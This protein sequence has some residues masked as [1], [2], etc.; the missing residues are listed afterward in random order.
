MNDANRTQMLDPNRTQLGNAPTLD[1]NRTVMGNAPSLNATQT[2]KPVQCPVCKSFNPTG[3]MFCVDCGLIFERAL[4]DDAFGAPAIQV[5]QLVDESGREQPLRPGETIIGRE[6][7]IMVTDGRASRRHAKITSANDVLHLE[8]L[9]STNGTKLNGDKLVAGEKRAIKGGDKI[10]FGGLEM[11][12]SMP[13][14]TRG[15]TTQAFASNKTSAISAP[16][17]V[18]K[19]PAA[20]VGADQEFPLKPGPNIFGRRAGN[21]IIVPDPYVSGKHGQ[22]E[23]TD[24]GIFLTDLG[25]SNGTF[26]NEAK[27]AHNMRTKITPDDTIRLGS[28]EFKVQLHA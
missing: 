24:E 27:L 28:L 6:G 17:A 1:P 10:S 22:I 3:V 13:G 2:I 11:Q 8:D 9:G 25:S 15:N 14:E 26:L 12:V 19:P 23:I 4:P 5:P 7:D 16:P 21:D 20:L 18:E